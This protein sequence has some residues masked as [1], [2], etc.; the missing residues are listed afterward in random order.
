MLILVTKN[1]LTEQLWHKMPEKIEVGNIL[2]F[3]WN[4][5][6]FYPHF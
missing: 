4:L 5:N 6:Q 1:Q 3:Y 2:S